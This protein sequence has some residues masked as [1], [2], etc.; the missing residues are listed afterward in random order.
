MMPHAGLRPRSGPPGGLLVMRRK[1]RQVRRCRCG[2]TR[3]EHQ[4]YSSSMTY[5][6]W[7]A[8]RRYRPR[9]RWNRRLAGLPSIDPARD[10]P[11]GGA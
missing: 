11:V 5:C 7:C 6:L 4:H 9:H 1:A 8:C 10:N 3:D 2:G